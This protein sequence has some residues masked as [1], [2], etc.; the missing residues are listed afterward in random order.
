M[1]RRT[2]VML[3]ATTI[4]IALPA[5]AA[6]PFKASLDSTNLLMG[7]TINLSF[8][9]LETGDTNGVVTLDMSSFPTEIEIVNANEMRP[10]RKPL[11]NNRYELT[12]QYILQSFDSG[13]YQIPGLLY[14]NSTGDTVQSNPLALK[15][16][17]VD[18]S[19]MTTIISD[20]SVLNPGKK[21]TDIFPSWWP[22]V[23]VGIII[24]AG[25]ICAYL[26]LARKVNPM[27]VIRKK[28]LPPYEVA[29]S[30]LNNL[31]QQN[32][33]DT[34]R[35]KQFYT[36]L[37]DIL[38]TYLEGRF[39]INAMEMTSSQIN[40]ALA[41]NPETRDSK[42]LMTEILQVAD[43]VKFAKAVPMR[44]ENLRNFNYAVDFVEL[45][46]PVEQKQSSDT[47]SNSTP[48]N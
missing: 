35:D 39:G 36:R 29:I 19:D 18:V 45:T 20:T 42:K 23:L 1:I 14:I 43:F 10:V 24:V 7:R 11:G 30:A 15:V 41:A 27:A 21:F 16:L 26:I 4:V 31:K 46:K 13:E 9:Y 5:K 34:G 48:G 2:M 28:E 22:W 40:N 37:T 32:L 47:D 8:S 33:L 3:A 44:E 38:R 6:S 25:G 17:P 12:G